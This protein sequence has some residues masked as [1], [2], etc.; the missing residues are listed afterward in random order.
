MVAVKFKVLGN[1]RFLSHAETL[2]VFQR[3]CVRAGI[4][5]RYSQGFN[6]R[7]KISLPVP[8][9]VGVE[10]EDELLCFKIETSGVSFDKEQLKERLSVQLPKGFELFSVEVAKSKASL[11]ASGVEYMLVVCDEL[12]DEWCSKLRERIGCLLASE[13]LDLDRQID[14]KGNMRNVDV[15][16]FLESIEFDSKS[17]MVKCKIGSAGSIRVG[18][19]MELLELDENVLELPIRRRK[20]EW[21]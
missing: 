6:P 15:R 7:P 2:K 12:S 9:S 21:G 10:S 14:A 17:I 8:R 4:K 1:V 18:E 3:A 20:V 16:P 13:S 19:I 11:K 5:I